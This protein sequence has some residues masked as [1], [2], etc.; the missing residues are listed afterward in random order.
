MS[1]LGD[2]LTSEECCIGVGAIPRILGTSAVGRETE[3]YGWTI[4]LHSL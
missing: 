1:E 3:W 4:R 2:M